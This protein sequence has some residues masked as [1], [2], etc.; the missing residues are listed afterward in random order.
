MPDDTR[1]YD[2]VSYMVVSAR[3]LLDETPLYG[4]FRLVDA[5]SRLIILL[6]EEGA[7][8]PELREL[9]DKI[10]TG[11]YSVMQD[12]EEFRA[13]LDSLITV[14]VD[15]MILHQGKG[16]VGENRHLNQEE[17]KQ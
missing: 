8:T 4:P 6:D 1:I 2:L 7:I 13:Y 15:K 3:N 10:E 11:K 14:I 5:A 17:S 9:R 16:V 12:Q